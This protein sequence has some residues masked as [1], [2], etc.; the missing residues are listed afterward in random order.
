MQAK[1]REL[2]TAA[3]RQ[4][5]ACQ[6]GEGEAAEAFDQ[7]GQEQDYQETGPL[8]Q[9]DYIVKDGQCIS[10]IAKEL[11]SNVVDDAVIRRRS[12]RLFLHR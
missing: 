12:A 11:W 2:Q 4:E 6:Q 10:S 5:A 9:G 7:T 1:Q 8:G 3:E